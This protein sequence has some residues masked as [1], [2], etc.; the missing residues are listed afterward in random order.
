MTFTIDYISL[1]IGSVIGFSAW[2]IPTLIFQVIFK[3]KKTNTGLPTLRKYV[4]DANNNLYDASQNLIKLNEFFNEVD[5]E[6][7]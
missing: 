5:N 1:G 4:Q 2:L 7:T 6:R 3:K